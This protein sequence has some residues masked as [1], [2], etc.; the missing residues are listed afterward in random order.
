MK[1]FILKTVERL[2][3]AKVHSTYDAIKGRKATGKED[4]AGYNNWRSLSGDTQ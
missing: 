3:G 4:M 2:T 1:K